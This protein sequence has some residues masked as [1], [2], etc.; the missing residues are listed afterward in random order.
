VTVFAIPSTSNSLTV[1]ITSLSATDNVLV[2]GY[3]LTE[4]ATKP[5]A[6]ASGWISVAP[7]TYTFSSAGAKTLYAWAKD[8]AGNVSS[9]RMGSV[10]ITLSTPSDTTAPVV[11]AFSIPPTSSSLA[12]SISTF[13]TSDNVAVTGYLLTEN[14]TK[15]FATASGWTSTKP[16]SYPFAS[17]GAKMLYAWAK[18]AAGNVSASRSAGV[19]ITLSSGVADISTANSLDLGSVKVNESEK[20]TLKVT[21]KGPVKLT[22]SKVE[23]IGADAS[24]FRLSA[25]SFN[26]MPSE[27]YDLKIDFKPTVQ[28]AYAA[29]LRIYSN[30]PDTPVKG[31][32]LSGSGTR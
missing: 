18:D 10:T 23:V 7:K 30:D 32:T 6:T 31:I 13:T 26:V 15:P 20:T 1:A 9:G 24:V 5:S 16:A 17:A 11:T 12:V 27:A 28:R 25:T 8:A 19:T 4:S 3:L 29:T 14:S 2:T 22:V 21:N